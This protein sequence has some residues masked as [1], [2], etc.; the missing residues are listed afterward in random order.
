[1]STGAAS[2]TS[3]T[4][5]VSHTPQQQQ[6]Q[7]PQQ[8]QPLQQQQQQQQSVQQQGVL[9]QQQALLRGF[10]SILRVRLEQQLA[11]T[12]R[13]LT[14]LRQSQGSIVDMMA[15]LMIND[16]LKIVF[17]KKS[18]KAVAKQIRIALSERLHRPLST[19]E[20]DYV[21]EKTKSLRDDVMET[22][23][24][25]TAIAK[26]LQRYS[27]DELK[28]MAIELDS[29]PLGRAMGK[30]LKADAQGRSSATHRGRGRASAANDDDDDDADENGDD[31]ANAPKNDETLFAQKTPPQ[32]AVIAMIATMSKVLAR[33]QYK[34]D[35]EVR[36]LSAG[37]LRMA[38]AIAT[39]ISKE[40]EQRARPSKRRKRTEPKDDEDVPVGNAE[41]QGNTDNINVDVEIEAIINS[42]PAGGDAGALPASAA[43]AASTLA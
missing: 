10:D 5:V 28:A 9:A 23:R 43:T 31:M 25:Q 14:A 26:L 6:Q 42:V 22:H 19:H 2:A 36:V 20:E 29:L 1:M 35:T 38:H 18:F 27:V 16:G 37:G 39:E 13:Q 41:A 34:C 4:P 7:H 32:V 40:L 12:N 21:I 15:E 24:V 3:V 11:E 30:R 33:D 17:T 8:L